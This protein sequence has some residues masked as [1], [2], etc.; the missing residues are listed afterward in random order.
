MILER[1]FTIFQRDSLVLEIHFPH[2]TGSMCAHGFGLVKSSTQ[3]KINHLNDMPSTKAVGDG[4]LL[5]Q[6]KAGSQWCV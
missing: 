6:L 5:R 1:D 2:A 3:L 4:L